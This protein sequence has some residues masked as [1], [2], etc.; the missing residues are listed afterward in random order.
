M[1]RYITKT[2]PR[3]KAGGPA[4]GLAAGS[5]ARRAD[6]II[7]EAA[8]HKELAGKAPRRRLYPPA[9]RP[10]AGGGKIVVTDYRFTGPGCATRK[11]VGWGGPQTPFAHRTAGAAA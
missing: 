6:V 9:K 7:A 4:C 3:P 8:N 10:A 5:P 2:C 11:P 1:R